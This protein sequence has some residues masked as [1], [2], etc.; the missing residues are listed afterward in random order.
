M[1][2]VGILVLAAAL[3]Y[4]ARR[5]DDKPRLIRGQPP[6][7]AW[8]ELLEMALMHRGLKASVVV[9]RAP[10]K[11]RVLVRGAPKGKLAPASPVVHPNHK[12]KVNRASNV[13]PQEANSAYPEGMKRTNSTKDKSNPVKLPATNRSGAGKASAARSKNLKGAK[14]SSYSGPKGMKGS[15]NTK[16]SQQISGKSVGRGDTKGY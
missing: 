16:Q 1:F 13:D 2:G 6:V 14:G 11:V 4:L 12:S 8:F 9:D 15:G 5:S 3:L 10:M 7:P